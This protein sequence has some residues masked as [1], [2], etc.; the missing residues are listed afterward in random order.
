[1][2]RQ[3]IAL[4]AKYAKRPNRTADQKSNVQVLSPSLLD[5]AQSR[6]REVVVDGTE[7]RVV[8]DGMVVEEVAVDGSR[9]AAAVVDRAAIQNS[10]AGSPISSL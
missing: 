4:P 5:R 2:R 3:W 8:D 10:S 7:V 6:C 1:M 9:A